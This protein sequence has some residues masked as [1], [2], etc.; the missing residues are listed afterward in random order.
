[1]ATGRP[2]DSPWVGRSYAHVVLSRPYV[3][4]ATRA[5]L[6]GA[7]RREPGWRAV[8]PESPPPLLYLRWRHER[9]ASLLA[10]VLG[11]YPLVVTVGSDVR[12]GARIRQ[13]R[14]RVVEAALADGG[15]VVADRE[16]ERTLG[17]SRERWQRAAAAHVTIEREVALTERRQCR[18]GGWSTYAA[19]H[20]SS[21]GARFSAADDATRDERGRA[22]AEAIARAEEELAALARG[23]GLFADWPRGTDSA[24]TPSPETP[25]EVIARD[26]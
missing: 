6:D 23:D 5:L 15:R 1:M 20:C 17:R 12:A 2:F 19:V 3:D 22:A 25:R 16:L 18:C 14:D 11:W 21:C 7:V 4:D 10:V 8:D 24:R 9:G 26:G 13:A